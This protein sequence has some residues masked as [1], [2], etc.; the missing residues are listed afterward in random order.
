[1]ATTYQNRSH[2]NARKPRTTKP[3]AQQ[4]PSKIT[5]DSKDIKIRYYFS[6]ISI[7]KYRKKKHLYKKIH[8]NLD[9]EIIQVRIQC[10]NQ[11]QY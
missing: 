11:R 3:I 4:P 2:P 9:L 7:Y 1:M 10:I 8:Q 5:N 6:F